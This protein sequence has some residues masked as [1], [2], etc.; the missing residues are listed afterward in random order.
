MIAQLDKTKRANKRRARVRGKVFGTGTRPRL[1]VAKSLRNVFAQV[2]DD[3]KMITLAAASSINKELAAKC[4]GRK[5]SAVAALVGEAIAKQA[6]EKGIK[7]VAL[8]R[9]RNLYHGRIKALAE[10]ARK[11]GLEF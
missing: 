10:A 9:N 2:I 7:Q 8:D 5:K 3:E 4:K 6:L 1:T 11:A